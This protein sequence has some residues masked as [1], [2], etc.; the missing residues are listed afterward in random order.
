MTKL[1]SVYPIRIQINAS[2]KFRFFSRFL[3]AIYNKTTII[4][5]TNNSHQKIVFGKF[6][7][8]PKLQC[9]VIIKKQQ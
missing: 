2:P 7:S 6:F 5:L 4:V 8:E 1:W 9:V 3:Y